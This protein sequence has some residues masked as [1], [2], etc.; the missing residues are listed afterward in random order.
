MELAEVFTLG[1]EVLQMFQI[2]AV[3]VL[4]FAHFKGQ[5]P[6][7]NAANDV[8]QIRRRELGA[9]AEAQTA[10]MITLVDY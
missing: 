8:V 1:H 3:M 2:K 4:R 6:W 10:E 9:V 7:R 5:Q